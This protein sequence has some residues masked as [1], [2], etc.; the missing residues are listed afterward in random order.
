MLC[1]SLFE[2][3]SHFL[4]SYIRDI[5]F[6]YLPSG[7]V[8]IYYSCEVSFFF[9]FSNKYTGF[10]FVVMTWVFCSTQHYGGSTARTTVVPSPST[11]GFNVCLVDG[12]NEVQD[13]FCNLCNKSWFT[14]VE[15]QEKEG[16]H[17]DGRR[18]LSPGWTKFVLA[19]KASE[20]RKR[21]TRHDF[22]LEATGKCCW[23][24]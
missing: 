14:Q 6:L 2:R 10:F 23:F 5:F 7:V 3:L 4:L 15:K 13:I 20:T 9:S 19:S 17:Q 21:A 18:N 22:R 16:P 24:Q 8:Y 1:V 12:E 11:S